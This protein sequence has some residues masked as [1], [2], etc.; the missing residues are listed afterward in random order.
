MIATVETV[1]HLCDHVHRTETD[2]CVA[3]IRVVDCWAIEES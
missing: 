2:V 1:D 3:R